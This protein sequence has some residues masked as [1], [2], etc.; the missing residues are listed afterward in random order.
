MTNIEAKYTLRVPKSKYNIPFE[1][2]EGSKMDAA[3]FK[4]FFNE[5]IPDYDIYLKNIKKDVESHQ[6]NSTELDDFI[7]ESL[8]NYDDFIIPHD[9]MQCINH[10]NEIE[11]AELFL[12]KY[13][14]LESL[15]FSSQF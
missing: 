12:K 11:D 8:P 5:I 10:N 9:F 7:K 14:M 3:V 13:D 1:V 6:S 2:V 4:D 15:K